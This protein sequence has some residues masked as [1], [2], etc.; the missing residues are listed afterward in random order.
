LVITVQPSAHKTRLP[1][2]GLLGSRHHH[3]AAKKKPGAR[4]HKVN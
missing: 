3:A 1:T 2:R 4:Y